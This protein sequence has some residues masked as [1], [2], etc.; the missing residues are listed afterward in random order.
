MTKDLHEEKDGLWSFQAPPLS[1]HVPIGKGRVYD[2]DHD[3]LA[4]LTYGNGVYFSLR[5]A[6]RLL[7]QEGIRC[8]VF[9]LRWLAPLDAQGM[10]R[11]ARE[12][13]RV[14][15]VDEGRRSGGVSEAMITALVEAGLGH[16]PIRRVVGE[17]TYIPLGPAANLVLPSEAEIESAARQLIGEPAAVR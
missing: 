8:R 10:A 14:L 12:C 2:E 11:H 13:G 4:I 9:D 3:D 5:V 6:K 17:D 7:D 16:L 15:V 1:E